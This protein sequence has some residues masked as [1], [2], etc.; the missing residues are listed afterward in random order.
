MTQ[1]VI[2]NAVCERLQ[3][4]LDSANATYRILDHAPEGRT[5]L[6]SI[7]RGNIL[8]E[9][10]KAMVLVAAKG[11]RSYEFILA[12]VGGDQR[13]DF[14]AIKAISG[15]SYVGLA[16]KEKAEELTGCVM[17][18]VPPFSFHPDLRLVVDRRLLQHPQIVFNAGR[19]DRSIFLATD[20][21]I[22]VARP[23]IRDI[24]KEAD[25]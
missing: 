21:Y 15:S 2:E 17:G 10:A 23:Q 9:A 7:I 14:N 6:A 11:K 20:L 25:R 18:S 12:V 1:N 8:S 4:V 5:D 19:L 3:Q 13:I 22:A 24:A 16:P